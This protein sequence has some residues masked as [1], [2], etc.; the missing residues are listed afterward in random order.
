MFDFLNSDI[1]EMGFELNK[2]TINNRFYTESV[3]FNK[4]VKKD[5]K[6]PH[7]ILIVNDISRGL[8]IDLNKVIGYI[9]AYSVVK[10]KVFFKTEIYN[11]YRHLTEGKKLYPISYRCE[12]RNRKD[13]LFHIYKY[14]IY[15]FYIDT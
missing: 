5:I 11:E 10:D 3:V 7:R 14:S 1:M 13:K 4:Y 12:R 2:P 9:K 15:G 6:K 8:T